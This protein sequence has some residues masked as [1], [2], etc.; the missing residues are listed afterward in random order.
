MWEI[1]KQIHKRNLTYHKERR[2]TRGIGE[3]TG[4]VI[5]GGL[6]IIPHRQHKKAYEARMA[7]E[8]AAELE[9]IERL[10]AVM[11]ALRQ[12]RKQ[13]EAR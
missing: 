11:R 2:D 10:N 12:Q 7:L 1:K 8:A 5:K 3:V 6:L 4:V 13:V 9:E